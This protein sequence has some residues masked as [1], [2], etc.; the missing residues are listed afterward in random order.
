MVAGA[1]IIGGSLVVT[2][3][4]SYFRCL[5]LDKEFGCLHLPQR[6]CCEMHRVHIA[7]IDGV[8]HRGEY[9]EYTVLLIVHNGSKGGRP[10]T[11]E[12]EAT[13]LEECPTGNSSATQSGRDLPPKDAWHDLGPAVGPGFKRECYLPV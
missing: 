9:H 8:A 1:A 13:A 6:V 2:I 10:I 3:V 12:G 7:R 11:C 5:P 4:R